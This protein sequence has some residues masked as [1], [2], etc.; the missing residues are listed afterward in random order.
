MNVLADGLNLWFYRL[1]NDA[2][3]L[4][5]TQEAQSFNHVLQEKRS[6]LV[7]GKG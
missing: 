2:E 3:F 6:V 4:S 1:A 5:Q 7:Q